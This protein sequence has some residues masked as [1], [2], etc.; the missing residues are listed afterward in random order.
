MAHDE[1][2]NYLNSLNER[3]PNSF[4]NVNVLDIG[5]LIIN[6]S[7]R[8]HFENSHILGVDLGPG[9]GVDIV[10]AGQDLDHPDGHYDV[11]CSCECF[12]HN[13]YWVE[14]F[15]NMIRMT[16]SGGLVIMTCATDGRPEHGTIRSKQYDAPLIPWDYYR[17]L[18]E[19]DFRAEFDLDQY[20]SEYAFSVD[21]NAHDLYF[22][23]IKRLSLL[24]F[25]R[26]QTEPITDKYD[27]G[28]IEHFYNRL[29]TPRQQNTSSLLEIGIYQGHSLKLW[30]DYFTNANIH[31]LDVNHC[32][33]IVNQP[34]IYPKFL[35]AYCFE[36]IRLLSDQQFDI[37]IDDGP[38]TL[39]S[40]KFY[41][42]NYIHL[43]KPGGIFVVE[44][45][46]DLRWTA[47][48]MD[49]LAKHGNPQ[50]VK[51]AGL[52]RTHYLQNLWANGLD[53]IVLEKS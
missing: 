6:G 26:S 2:K 29:F 9:P 30:R 39:E 7:I 50:I 41:C 47:I 5:S 42:E 46:I 10:C 45:I 15:K 14:T 17:N 32:A 21:T 4:R 20:F 35:D 44:D 22:Y 38:H 1:Q 53:V 37:I 8:E 24:E 51:M 43:V 12:E 23:G 31:G 52:A 49:I 16:R 36:T 25:T 19:Q 34:R 11:V 40:L 28:Y 33:E 48:L 27:L 18:N 3:F 13:P